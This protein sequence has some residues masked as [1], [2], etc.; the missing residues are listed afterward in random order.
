MKRLFLSVFLLLPLVSVATDQAITVDA[1]VAEVVVYRDQAQV[2]RTGR[3]ELPAGVS[4]LAISG[5]PRQLRDD[6]LQ[7][8]GEG[9]AMLLLDSRLETGADQVP[10]PA[11][12]AL[13]AEYDEEKA[14]R[15]AVKDKLKAL[16]QRQRFLERVEAAMTEPPAEGNSLPGLGQWREY[17]AF[18]EQQW[19]SVLLSERDTKRQLETHE[20]TLAKLKERIDRYRKDRQLA[21]T[22]FLRVQSDNGGEVGLQLSYQVRGASWTPVYDARVNEQKGEVDLR[23]RATVSQQTGELWEDVK[24]VLSTARPS[25]SGNVPELPRWRLQPQQPLARLQVGRAM[26]MESAGP[27]ADMAMVSPAA[28]VDRG[29]IAARFAIAAPVTVTP[30]NSPQLVSIGSYTLA[31]DFEYTIVPAMSK[32]AYLQVKADYNGDAPLLP[33]QINIFFNEAQSGRASM[34]LTHQGSSLDLPV[35]INEAIAIEYEQTKRHVQ[36]TGLINK[37]RRT[38]LAW[39]SVISNNS[40]RGA[41]MRVVDR[42][43]VSEHDDIRV[44]LQKP[45]KSHLAEDKPGEIHWHFE[46]AAGK[47]RT[48]DLQYRVEHPEDMLVPD[49]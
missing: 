48:L 7:I 8:S 31:G 6:S 1:P 36:T 11:L 37:T 41:S 4:L 28:Q 32:Q 3:V 25:V 30:D 10:P 35:G 5:L 13:L 38:D 27:M 42:I 19:Q 44:T 34:P 14:R 18:L 15:D 45:D 20:E 9:A 24:L 23:Y 39:R 16:A 26:M 12:Q 40:S 22:A 17:M 46:L 47:S 33:G 29:M 2:T 43:P 49:L 21:K